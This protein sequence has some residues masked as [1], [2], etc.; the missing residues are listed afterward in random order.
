MLEQSVGTD[1]NGWLE[2]LWYLGFWLNFIYLIMFI[3]TAIGL[4]KLSK[5]LWDTHSW[6]A[7]VPI[8]QLYTFIKTSGY[9]MIKW[10]LL[11]ILFF[12]IGLFLWAVV[13]MWMTTVIWSVFSWWNLISIAIMGML[14]GI[15]TWLIMSVTTTFFL[16]SWMAKRSHQSWGTALLMTLFPWCMLWI[17]ANRIPENVNQTITEQSTNTSVE[18]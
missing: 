10:I 18:L 7:F 3:A 5:K 11:L 14:T 8:I 16:Y 17:V 2:I 13:M 9:G 1:L 12:I 6:L 15:L 4:Y